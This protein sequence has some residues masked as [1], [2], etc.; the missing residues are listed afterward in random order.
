[1]SGDTRFIF[2]IGATFVL[3]FVGAFSLSAWVE[4]NEAENKRLLV[5]N[6]RPTTE[7]VCEAIQ[8]V[9]KGDAVTFEAAI[10]G[11]ASQRSVI[12]CLF[13]RLP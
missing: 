5:K 1:M 13:A 4:I 6:L 11:N 8:Q 7:E 10:P 12:S 2:T 3:F 9:P